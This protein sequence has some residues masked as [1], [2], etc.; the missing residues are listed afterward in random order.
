[1]EIFQLM[2]FVIP[3]FSSLNSSVLFLHGQ[4][5]VVYENNVRAKG[6]TGAKIHVNKYM[7]KIPLPF[8]FSYIK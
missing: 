4:R 3:V 2:V 8:L 7:F 1:M 6:E 5:D